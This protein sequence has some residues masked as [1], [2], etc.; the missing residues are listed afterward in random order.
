[1]MFQQVTAKGADSLKTALLLIDIQYFYFPGSK[2]A[3]VNPEAASS[4]AALLLKKFRD[5]GQLV[6][7]VKHNAKTGGE[8]YPDV[9]PLPDEKVITKNHVNSFLE[10][11][12]L[13]YLQKNGIRRLILCGMMTHMCVEGTARAAA[14]YGFDC[15]VI[16]DA[17]ATRDLK[18]ED[19]TIPAE[20]VHLSTLSTISYAYGRV[21]DTAQFLEEFIICP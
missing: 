5:A 1:M 15:T 17:C 13:D 19:K 21:M 4:N 8:I 6:V 14:D 9:T 16:G 7:H 18:Y 10:T 20:M 2:G 11:D 12:L 3:L